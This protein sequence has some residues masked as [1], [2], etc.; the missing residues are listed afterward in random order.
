[1]LLLF[2]TSPTQGDFWWSDAP[3]HAMDGVFYYDMVRAMPISHAK[4]WAINYYLQY[5]AVTVLTY[6]PLFALVEAVFF[7]LFGVSHATAQLTVSAFY[8]AAAWGAYF[9]ARRW[10]SRIGALAAALLFAS[11]PAIA[12]WG[13]QVMLEVPTFAFLLWSAYFFFLYLDSDRPRYL[14]FA[15]LVV[16]GAAYT[17]QPAVFIVLPYLLT[18]YF[19]YRN[20]LFRRK[21]VWW[22]GAL[23]A[24]VLTPLAIYTW[25]WG[26]ANVQQ[27]VGGG[28]VQHSRLSASTWS[29]VA[30]YE[31]PLQM[32]WV[33]LCLAAAYC[34]GCIFKKEWR[35]PNPVLF[36]LVVWVLSGYIFFT[37]IAV[38][39]QRYTIFLIF[40]FV[41]FAILAIVRALPARIAVYVAL[42][43]AISSLGY[44]LAK[45]HVPCITGYRDAAQYVC[46]MA[47][48]N[49]VVMFSG[50]RDGSFVFNVRALPQCKNLT[51]IRA[52]KLLLKVA[53]HRDLFGVKELGVAETKLKEMLGH[54]GVHY[55]VI[56]PNFWND[57][58]SM[59]MLVQTLHQD[60]FKLLNTISTV[61]NREHNGTTLEIYEN[62]AP[63]SPGKNVLRVELPV[64]GIA[65]E[66]KV[67][68]GDVTK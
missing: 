2:K 13:R 19:V 44:T 17:K 4:Q 46:S 58:Q 51:V 25:L 7:A 42:V 38:T 48:Q 28:W 35:L 23:F 67:G 6:P 55:I 62:L 31:W 8:L 60:Q 43:F 39:S 34:V 24:A 9:L 61:N 56:E 11:T 27:A 32:G 16:L 68:Q 37:V 36:F 64:S 65:V 63:L 5:P 59:Q 50:W 15:V 22:S 3:R 20:S 54:F 29:Y 49:S 33:V 45:R 66:G 57:L 52:D 12:L 14:Y 1:V 30:S 26:R 47:P 40:P 18:L 21:E 53:I 41:L 10:L